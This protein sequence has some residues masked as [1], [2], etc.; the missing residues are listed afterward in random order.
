MFGIGFPELLVVLVLALLI[1]GPAKLPE[2]ARSL[3]RGLAEFRRASNE[4]RSSIMTV[5]E[6]EAPSV[7]P[8]PQ[9]PADQM[10][11]APLASEVANATGPAAPEAPP[12]RSSESREPSDPNDEPQS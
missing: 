4:L 6:P 10:A 2:L 8:A 1:F 11:Q 3:G 9:G 7:Q 5:A 12:A